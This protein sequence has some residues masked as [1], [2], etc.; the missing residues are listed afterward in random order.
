MSLLMM[1]RRGA[2]VTGGGA[3]AANLPPGLTLYTDTTYGQFVANETYANGLAVFSAIKQADDAA[4]PS[5]GGSVTVD[6]AIW[7]NVTDA[8]AP[9][10]PAGSSP[11]C[12][13][14]GY[15]EGGAGNG[16]CD[17]V[18]SGTAPQTWVRAYFAMSMLVSPNYVW[19]SNAEKFFYPNF[20]TAGRDTKAT[21]IGWR[22]ATTD[23]P[24]SAVCGWEADC[25]VPAQPSGTS[26]VLQSD[27]NPARMQKGVWQK[28]EVYVQVNT[29]GNGDGVLRIWVDGVIAI[30]KT[31]MRYTPSTYFDAPQSTIRAAKFEGVRGGGASTVLVPTGGMYRRFDRLAFYASSSFV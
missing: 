11:N 30:E 17:S 4:I 27:A 21:S 16:F 20:E 1:A 31:D 23:N 14:I 6:T 12:T 24:N 7:R 18:I 25:Q 26:Y 19:H 15:V 2:V 28:V 29:P 8:T 10:K 3:F 5:V 9:Y 22:L 13:D